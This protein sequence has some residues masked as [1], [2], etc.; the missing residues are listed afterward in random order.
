VNQNK[1]FF[2]LFFAIAMLSTC[3]F[4]V[5]AQ[6]SEQNTI[7]PFH[8]NFPQV[9]LDDLRQRVGATRWP[10]K[11]TVTDATQGV[12]LATMQKLARYWQTDYDW[13]KFEA[14]LNALSQFMTNID[15]VDIHFIHVRSKHSNA[16]PLIITHG[17]PDSVVEEL[18]VIDPLTNPT[19]YGGSASDAFDIVIPSMP[20]YGFYG[21]P[22]KLSF[23]V[24]LGITTPVAV[25][26]FPDELYQAPRSWAERAYPKLI[27]YNKLAKGGHFA[28]WEQ[29]KFFSEELRAAFRSL[30]SSQ[31][32]RS[33][34]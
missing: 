21:K 30:R 7:R 34:F 31:L 26:A 8:V 23:F 3:T 10:G 2:V 18:K 22:N 5:L 16:L 17:W 33:Q 4:N 27:H 9:A 12:Q 20:G 11:E 28:A 1:K 19:A 13:R 15:G 32:T 6:Q 14:R 29:P 25:S 24:P